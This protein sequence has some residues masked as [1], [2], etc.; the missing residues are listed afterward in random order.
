[1]FNDSK[2]QE[3]TKTLVETNPLLAPNAIASLTDLAVFMTHHVY[4]VWDF[5]CLAKTVQRRI[6]PANITWTPSRNT[7]MVRFIN[8]MILGEESDK[9][10][11][12]GEEYIMSH[13]EMYLEAMHEV[14]NLIEDDHDRK[15]FLE[16]LDH[17][18][19]TFHKV[20]VWFDVEFCDDDYISTVVEDS[21]LDFMSVTKKFCYSR[22]HCA[23]AAFAYGRENLIP[24]MF[25][26]V[27]AHLDDHN[28]QTPFFRKYLERHIE[29]DGEEHGPMAT[30]LVEMLC[31][32]APGM[33]SERAYIEAENAAL[34]AL[35]ARAKFWVAV[36]A[37]ILEM[38]DLTQ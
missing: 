22:I 8:E 18:E 27:L 21:V 13:F 23:A 20:H 3:A 7:K 14:F 26:K 11:I 29:L 1:M 36:N 5:M 34:Q 6:A 24:S 37:K 9:F 32:I 4:A 10:E 33:E 16:I 38:R 2:I 25:D 12:N 30:Q 15:L 35:E 19:T 17:I 28:L 31:D